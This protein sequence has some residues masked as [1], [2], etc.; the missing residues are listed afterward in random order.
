MTLHDP[1]FPIDV[2][3]MNEYCK[4]KGQKQYNMHRQK[5]HVQWVTAARL[6]QLSKRRSAEREAAGSSPGRTNTQ[7]L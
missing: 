2:L 4:S 3:N 6:A 5:F 7:G 1:Y